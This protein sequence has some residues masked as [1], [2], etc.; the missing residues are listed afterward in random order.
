MEIRAG[1]IHPSHVANRLAKRA[2]EIGPEGEDKMSGRKRP[3]WVIGKIRPTRQFSASAT[4]TVADLSLA[5]ENGARA[6][7]VGVSAGARWVTRCDTHRRCREW[8]T[9]IEAMTSAPKV[10]YWCIDCD[11][12][13][14]NLLTLNERTR[15]ALANQGYHPTTE[16]KPYGT[17]DWIVRVWESSDAE[18]NFAGT[19]N[20]GEPAHEGN[21]LIFSAQFG[22]ETHL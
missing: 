20:C 6:E 9:R 14:T 8:R 12:E 19:M 4:V 15:S 2:R 3:P 10:W 13:N 7:Y 17:A 21:S 18:G 1:K 16:T 5:S 22:E 11:A